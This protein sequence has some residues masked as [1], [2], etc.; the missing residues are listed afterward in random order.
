MLSRATAGVSGGCAMFLLPGSE[1]RRAAGHEAADPAGARAHRTRADE[2]T[3]PSRPA[4]RS[5]DNR[6]RLLMRP[7]TST[8]PFADALRI[9]MDA[10]RPI[11][12]TETIALADGDGRVAAADLVATMDVPPFDRAAMDGYAVI[13]ADTPSATP[14][15]PARRWR[16]SVAC[17]RARCRRARVGAGECIEIATG[18][19]MPPGADAVVMVED[20]DARRR[21]H[22]HPCQT[23]SAGQNIG[24][25]GAD[26]ARRPD[27]SCAPASGSARA[28]S[29]RW[30][31]PA[32]HRCGCSRGRRWRFSRPATK[33]STRATPL[34]PGQIY[35]I[36]RFTLGAVVAAHG[37]VAVAAAAGRR[38]ARR[39]RT[40]ARR[41]ARARRRGVLGRQ[42]RRRARSDARR[43]ARARRGALSRHRRKA[44]QADGVRAR[45]TACR[46]S[47]MPGLSDVVSVERAT[48]CWCRSCA[49]SPGCRPG[50]RARRRCR[51]RAASRRRPD[52]H[53]FY[54]VRIV[55]GQAEP[56]FKA[57]GDITSMANADGYIEIPASTDAI[58]AGTSCGDDVPSSSA[59]TFGVRVL[60]RFGVVALYFSRAAVDR[61]PVDHVPP[62]REVVGPAVLVLQVVGVLPDVDAE[63]GLLAFHHRVVLVGRALDRE[64]AAATRRA[65]PSRCRSGRRRPCS[66]V[67]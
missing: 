17:S 7:F 53:Q 60:R 58:E 50:S 42:L 4:S 47:R 1:A 30:P 67:P 3:S 49:P 24:R 13:A 21:Q 26:I 64:L 61:V 14:A 35:D 43:A 44:R 28:A 59:G 56:A 57:S 6:I 2:D 54:T 29:A 19:P 65:T 27:R 45:S 62:G 34:A 18:A 52:R 11:D 36:N 23:P 51:C 33:S 32:R 16:A 31:P 66:S 37:G 41:R 15:T 25:R 39:A 22:Q 55:D 46:C 5:L 20:T 63:D 48:C 8:M 38:L 40:R 10:A 12:R 9:V